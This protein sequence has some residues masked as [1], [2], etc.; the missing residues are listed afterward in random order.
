MTSLCA[1]ARL[2]ILD[3]FCAISLNTQVRSAKDRWNAEK[4][5]LTEIAANGFEKTGGTAALHT[6][7]KTGD[8]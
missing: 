5:L 3:H 2:A 4:D 7:V 8:P 1:C 6:T